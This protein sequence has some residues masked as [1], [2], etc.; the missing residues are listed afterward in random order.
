MERFATPSNG[1]QYQK[2]QLG[3]IYYLYTM[4][5]IENNI[6]L[7]LSK[8]T[9]KKANT[10]IDFAIDKIIILN[11]EVPVKFTTSGHY[12]V[13]I[14]KIVDDNHDKVLKRESLL[15]CDDVSE[16]SNDDKQQI[17]IKLHHEFSHPFSDKLIT[18]LKD[19]NINDKQ[20]FD[21]IKNKQ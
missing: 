6:P 20:L 9:I 10:Q 5:V 17:V 7:L 16:L 18:L 3:R 4:D 1:L 8:D 11:K 14:G 19:A 12:C 13:P 21:M 15:F 2:F